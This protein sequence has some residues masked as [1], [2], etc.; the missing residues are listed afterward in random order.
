[1]S[2]HLR[3]IWLSFWFGLTVAAQAHADP[4]SLNQ[5]MARLNTAGAADRQL[6][7]SDTDYALK[8]GVSQQDIYRLASL[9][10][11][12]NYTARDVAGFVE[13][14]TALKRN[15]LPQGLVLEKI[16]EGMAKHVPA[17]RILPVAAL[18]AT[19]LENSNARIQDMEKKGLTYTAATQRPALVDAGATLQQLYGA[20]QALTALGNAAE[21]SGRMV[22]SAAS[23]VAATQLAETLLLYGAK[24]D[25]ALSLSAASLRANYDAGQILGLQR[26][27]LEQL[28]HGQSL[29]DI[30]AEQRGP[31]A[32]MQSLTHA[33]SALPGLAKGTMPGG[34]SGPV[35]PAGLQGGGVRPGG[36]ASGGPGGGF[37][38]MPGRGPGGGG[39]MGR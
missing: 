15:G 4:A 37:S 21:N 9:A 18:W 25:Q 16:L 7:S 13:K 20:P 24:P 2:I 27:L 39:A 33:S 22:R 12:Q 19:A 30:I 17:T 8:S 32:A 10:A 3:I 14:I 34:F 38:G 31:F 29:A 28:G 23:L 6:L 36:F 11:A 35:S 26:S 5:E 1:M